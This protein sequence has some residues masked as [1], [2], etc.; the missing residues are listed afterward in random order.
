MTTQLLTVRTLFKW[1]QYKSNS[2]ISQWKTEGKRKDH[3][4]C[5]VLARDKDQFRGNS[6]KR[7]KSYILN[8]QGLWCLGLWGSKWMNLMK[9]KNVTI[10]GDALTMK[11][12]W[13]TCRYARKCLLRSGK[14]STH[15]LSVS[16]TPSTQPWSPLPNPSFLTTRLTNWIRN[17]RYIVLSLERRFRVRKQGI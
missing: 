16:W 3:R 17:G 8:T 2:K 11:H 12:S 14:S 6:R 1:Q 9:D 7:S 10:V 13:S 4:W 5:W 15:R